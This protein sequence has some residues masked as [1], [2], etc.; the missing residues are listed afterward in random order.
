MP[1]SLSNAELYTIVWIAALYIE[2]AAA[3]ILLDHRHDAPQGFEQHPS[4]TNSYSWGRMGKHN[5][6][7]ASLPAGHYGTVSAATTAS[8]L[9]ASLP[10]LRFGLLVGI[11]G[12]VPRRL[13]IRLGDVVV[14]HP[15]GTSGGVVQYDLGK[16][17]V[18]EVWERK[19]SLNAP[20]TVLLSALANLRAEHEISGTRIPE[21]LQTL[22]TKNPPKL[23]SWMYQGAEQDRLFMPA[24]TH[25][26][27]KTCETCDDSFEITRTRRSSQDPEIH[28]GIIASGNVL[29]KDAAT[30]DG[31]AE[32][33][34]EQCVCVEMEAAGLMQSFPCLVIRGICDYADSHKNDR[35]QRYASATAAAY[36][37]ELLDYIPIRQ[38]NA[39]PQLVQRL[40]PEC[41]KGT[42][43][44]L[45]D[46]IN[47]WAKGS[48]AKS[49][50]WLNGMAGTGKSTISRTLS[51][52][53]HE[54]GHLGASFFF[55]RG[56]GDRGNASKLFTTI[57]KQL[58]IRHPDLAIEIKK[59]IVADS[60]IGNKGLR[61]Q[62]R[63]LILEP[64]KTATSKARAH[65]PVILMIDALDESEQ[66]DDIRVIISLLSLSRGTAL[67]TF[68]T[69]RPELPIRLGFSSIKEE[70]RDIVLHEVPPPIMKRDL[71]LYL[72]Y[73]LE[74]IRA[75]YNALA[76]D[77]E[78]DKL[79][80]EWPCVPDFNK[81]LE[82]VTPLFIFAATV[83]RFL[84][85]PRCGHP[86]E[87]LQDVLR[88]QT[89]SQESK[90]DM[91]Y[92]PVLNRLVKDLSNKDRHRL[93]E[94]FKTIVGSI[95]VLE[96]PLSTD[97]LAKILDIPKRAITSLLSLL[98][99]VLGVPQSTISP[100]RLLH[101]SFRDFLLD[102]EKRGSEFWV[103]ATQTHNHI[104]TNCLR[105][106]NNFLREDMC[107]LRLSEMEGSIIH[108]DKVDTYIPS[109]VQYA[110]LYWVSHLQ[111]GADHVDH[112]DN[113]LDFLQ[114]HFLHWVEALSIMR[115]ARDSFS[116]LR[117]LERLSREKCHNTL[118]ALL[119]DAIRIVHYNSVIIDKA[120]L[121]LYS[122]V[123]IFA[124]QNSIIRDIF[125]KDMPHW[126]TIRPRTDED[127]DP[128][129]YVIG[130]LG[131]GS[132]IAF[133]HDDALIVSNLDSGTL[134]LSQTDTGSCVRYLE[135]HADRIGSVI[136]SHDS[137]LMASISIDGNLRIWRTET[138]ECIHSLE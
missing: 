36:A 89:R 90:L 14:S 6:V 131:Q 41:L 126:I 78:D 3:S 121:Q 66:D 32:I 135:G 2:R 64:L 61:Q 120:P 72:N 124:P 13:D 94:Q 107:G 70:Y 28:Y 31:V 101:L 81:L 127:W 87:L 40:N 12:G 88:F 1:E 117:K 47:E 53:F 51:R 49:I 52:S 104:A 110:C 60:T 103:D 74:S 11:G 46:E 39:T 73:Q 123:L 58:A 92:L 56:E 113:V 16:A 129:S 10:H 93:V 100:V 106:M 80:Q 21:F 59:A 7:I 122:S 79:I 114:S 134:R 118:T 35:W 42:R 9:A 97:T 130:D 75:E 25:T 8:N 34:G 109:E 128:C 48:N 112:L 105:V 116:M 91:T 69:S 50:F 63:H 86:D 54:L 30:R 20:P 108:H 96:S 68:I 37:K 77:D 24:Y 65:K 85:D 17:T 115:R 71:R 29:V 43:V 4:D 95:V 125:Q 55:K 18:G 45:L 26:S 22:Q 132:K 137:S 15:E 138:G 98:H 102:S 5:I 136:F 67:R 38:L 62:F 111:S 84:G 44:E 76:Q 27:S 133:S 82:M 99:S 57:A 19:G 33:V 83:C 119:V 23:E